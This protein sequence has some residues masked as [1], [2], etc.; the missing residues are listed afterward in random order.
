MASLERTKTGL[1]PAC[2]LPSFYRI[3]VDEVNLSALNSHQA[4]SN[5]SDSANANSLSISCNSL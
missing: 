1:V 2:S 3:Q 4:I 5:P